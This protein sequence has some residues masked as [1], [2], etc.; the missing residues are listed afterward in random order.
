MLP[1][2]PLMIEHRLIEQMIAVIEK[3]TNLFRQA[4]MA[5]PVFIYRA[6]DFIRNY[7]DLCHHGKEEGILFH[8]LAR[9]KLPLKHKRIMDEL[10]NEHHQ[11]RAKVQELVQ[12]NQKYSAGEL[13]ALPQI[14]KCL[15][16]LVDF[17]PKHIEK[18][19]QHFFLPCMDYFS[20]DEKKVMLG[21]ERE[22]DRTMVHRIY[23]DKV[24]QTVE[25]DVGTWYFR[26][27]RR[28]G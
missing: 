16:F 24:K 11:A 28:K 4:D 5:N 19:D 23:Q 18:E 14:L 13:K 6:I 22:F 3:Q 21:E 25:P 17:Y 15:D 20:A 1:V 7:A 10:I 26:N 8:Q 12:A 2:A 9:K 27:C